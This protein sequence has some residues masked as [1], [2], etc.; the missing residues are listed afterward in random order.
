MVRWYPPE[1]VVVVGRDILIYP[2]PFLARKA[3][4]VGAT[5]RRIRDLN[6]DLFDTM[7]A[8]DGIGLAATQVGWASGSSS[9]T[10]LRWTRRS[11][12]WPSSI[13]R[14]SPGKDR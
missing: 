6:R 9:S 1:K 13:P 10:S 4:P 12:P 7:Y 3:A 2:D 8:S 11:S 5:G 14:S